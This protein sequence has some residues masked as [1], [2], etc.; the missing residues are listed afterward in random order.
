ML[1][2]VR[3]QHSLPD[4][5]LLLFLKASQVT[6]TSFVGAVEPGC[7]MSEVLRPGPGDCI[8]QRKTN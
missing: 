5:S 2:Q 4:R 3:Y 8:D 6:D 1:T 7:T